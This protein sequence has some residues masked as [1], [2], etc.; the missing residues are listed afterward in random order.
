MSKIEKSTEDFEKEI[1]KEIKVDSEGKGVASI[2]ATARLVGIAYST[3][4]YAL[5]ISG[6]KK[7]SKLAQM[8]MGNGFNPVNFSD[9]G[10]PDIAVALIVKF[11]AWMNGDKCTEQAKSIDLLFT[12]IATRVWMQKVTGWKPTVTQESIEEFVAKQLPSVPNVWECRFP[13]EFWE[14]LHRVYGLK[15]GDKGCAMFLNAYI[16]NFFPDEVLERLEEINPMRPEGFRNAKKHQHFDGIMLESLKKQIER[17]MM[18]LDMSTDKNDFR[19]LAKRLT[20]LRIVKKA[21]SLP[22]P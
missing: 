7:P 17:V 16:Y 8:L 15:R 20:K 1:A 5:D 3:L 4:S 2:R 11:Y 18:L 21:K 13:V 10:I 6:Q 22:T 9:T 19:S 14:R 12:T